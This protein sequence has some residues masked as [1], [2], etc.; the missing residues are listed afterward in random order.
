MIEGL[1]LAAFAVQKILAAAGPTF[2]A[3]ELIDVLILATVVFMLVPVVVATRP[4]SVRTKEGYYQL[5]DAQM[6]QSIIGW[7][8]VG[9]V[10]LIAFAW[11]P[12]EV[13]EYLKARSAP[14]VYA[15]MQLLG[16]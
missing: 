9:V 6:A 4:W 14:E 11:L 13:V 5:T 16:K 15:A 8:M 12:C 1:N 7:T 10:W 3:W 2:V